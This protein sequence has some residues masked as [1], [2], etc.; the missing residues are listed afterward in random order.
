MYLFYDVVFNTYAIDKNLR[1]I[2]SFLNAVLPF[3]GL[4]TV[5]I[6]S[7]YHVY[8]SFQVSKPKDNSY[9]KPNTNSCYQ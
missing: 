5:I 2:Y 4:R 7:Y 6:L 3:S 1:A 8:A 9:E